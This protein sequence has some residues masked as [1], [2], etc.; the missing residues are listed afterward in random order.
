MKIS[1]VISMFDSKGISLIVYVQTEKRTKR[2]YFEVG[3]LLS[4]ICQCSQYVINAF[5]P[6]LDQNGPMQS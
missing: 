5:S 3:M 2:H 1:Q 6:S 4:T